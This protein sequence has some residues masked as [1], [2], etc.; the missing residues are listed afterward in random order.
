MEPRER[1]E[2]LV[3]RMYQHHLKTTGGLPTG[4]LKRSMEK[5]AQMIAHRAES[6]HKRGTGRWR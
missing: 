3:G 1:V 2:R 6:K 5:K 4:E